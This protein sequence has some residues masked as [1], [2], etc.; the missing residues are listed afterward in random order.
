[1][2]EW[3][4]IHL[5]KK[6]NPKRLRKNINEKRIIANVR[7]RLVAEQKNNGF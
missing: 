1:M 2:V 7:L 5:K 4:D 6:K 3:R